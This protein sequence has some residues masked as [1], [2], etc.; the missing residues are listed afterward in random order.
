MDAITVGK[1]IAEYRKARGLTQRELAERLHV[2]DGAVSKWE[3]GINFPDLALLEPLAGALDIDVIVLL[4]L[5][6]ASRQEIASAV[7]DISL[8]EKK[9]LIKEFRQREAMNILIGL[10][11]IGCLVTASLLFKKYEIYGLAH[12]IT[13]GAI[14]FVSTMIGSEI[15]LLRNINRMT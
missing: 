3:R 12:G 11:L 13:M 8:E 15:F 5:E 10:I 6:E 14:G 1:R 7:T 4:A 9:K 2:T